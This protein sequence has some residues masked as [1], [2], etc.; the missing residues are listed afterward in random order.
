MDAVETL[1]ASFDARGIQLVPDG[2][3]LIVRPASKLTEVDRQEINAHKAAL[4]ARARQQSARTLTPD[5]RHPLICDVV[6]AKIEAIEAEARAKGWPAELLWNAGFWDRPR[7]LAAV[8][9][10][11]DEV[12]EVTREIIEIVRMHRHVLRFP[13][14][15]A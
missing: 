6:R 10:I 8:L 7:G 5:S 15:N 4:L 11:D 13:R 3:G 9:E 12:G 1:L 2:N 14:T